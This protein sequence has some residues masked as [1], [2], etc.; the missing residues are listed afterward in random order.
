MR[1]QK[2]RL[3]FLLPLDILPEARRLYLECL[4]KTARGRLEG[5]PEIFSNLEVGFMVVI[6]RRASRYALLAILITWAFGPPTTNT[7]TFDSSDATDLVPVNAK[8]QRP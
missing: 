3:R 7:Q 1:Q 5:R 2:A 8:V 4:L 6:K